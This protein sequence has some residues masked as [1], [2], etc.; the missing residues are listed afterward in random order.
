M[1]DSEFSEL[2]RTLHREMPITV[3]MGMR[4]VSWCDERLAMQMP[5]APNRNHQYSAF[6]GSLNALCT[7]VGWG[8]VFLLVRR[9]GLAGNIVIRRGS[10][11]YLRPVRS[12]EIIARGLP[13][14]P[15]GEA[16][17]FE[18]LRSKGRSKL[19]VSAEIADVEGPLVTFTGSYVVQD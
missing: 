19:D 17:F 8:T 6:A 18:L 7:V 14:D 16:F 10:I 9:E 13:L 3:P 2:E 1:D 15:G 5:L 12:P 4:A 11:R